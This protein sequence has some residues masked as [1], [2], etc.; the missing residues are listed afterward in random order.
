MEGIFQVTIVHDV[1][2]GS[3][4]VSSPGAEDPLFVMN[5]LLGG[6]QQLIAQID[7]ARKDKPILYTAKEVPKES[8]TL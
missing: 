6:I 8:S 7:A 3:Y 4:T 2:T 1:R 5:V